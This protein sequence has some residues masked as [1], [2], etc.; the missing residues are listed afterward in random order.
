MTGNKN[1]LKR[2]EAQQL[3]IEIARLLGPEATSSD[4]FDVDGFFV[5]RSKGKEVQ[6]A[7]AAGKQSK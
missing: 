3:A 7:E 1:D 6:N 5:K 2:S 4:P